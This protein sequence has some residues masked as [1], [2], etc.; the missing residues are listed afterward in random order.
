VDALERGDIDL[1]ISTNLKPPKSIDCAKAFA[2]RIVCICRRRHPQAAR[3]TS[4]DAF[5]ALPQIRV[6]QSP[7]DDRFADRQLAD[8]GRRRVVALTVPHW[9]TVPEI[10]AA[11]DLIC[12]MPLSIAARVVR[13]N[14]VRV[15]DPPLPNLAFD[16]MI[17]WHRRSA[18]DRGHAWL[19]RILADIS[20]EIEAQIGRR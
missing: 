3:L 20:A 12:V 2:D 10:V 16:W 9:L 1:A 11:S 7:I 15:F 6:A 8:A 4:L 13:D 14:R 19:R 18:A 5:L 17:Y